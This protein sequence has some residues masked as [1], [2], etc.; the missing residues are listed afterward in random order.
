MTIKFDGFEI[1]INAKREGGR[2]TKEDTYRII[3]YI[4][5]LAYKAEEKHE[6]DGHKALAEQAGEFAS[7]T[8]DELE[9]VGY[10]KF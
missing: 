5:T 4:S 7:A 9:K 3:N 10:Y 1:E 8:Y 6:I 2:Y